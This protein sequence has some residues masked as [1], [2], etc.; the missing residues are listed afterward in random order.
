ME[1]LS[2][3]PLKAGLYVPIQ[4]YTIYTSGRVSP[5]SKACN[6]HPQ[7]EVI[8]SGVTVLPQKGHQ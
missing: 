5:P 4:S 6:P 1:G 3:H 8:P 7:E 2:L